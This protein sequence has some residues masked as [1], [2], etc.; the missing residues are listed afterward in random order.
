[1]LQLVMSVNVELN[2]KEI[3]IEVCRNII[4]MLNR[5]KLIDNIEKTFNIIL[6][7]INIKAVIE[8]IL[9]NNTKLSIY[10]VNVKLNSIAQGTPLDDYLSNNLDIHKI[11]I[12][13]DPAKKVLKQI[14][15]EY[16]NSEFFF[17]HEMLED[18]PAKIFIPE[19]NI[20]NEYEKTELLS[21]FGDGE[22]SIIFDTD[23]MARHFGATIGDIFKIIR[24]NMG[25]G[26]SIFYR[27]VTHGSLDLLVA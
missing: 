23:T 20:L 21:K 7:D 16:K 26:T 27:R 22:L 18:I 6:P 11:V 8:I 14:I 24:P 12:L 13:R 9:N 15:T 2:S 5:R 3:N 10:S 17:E 1:M 25:S 19:H 4:K